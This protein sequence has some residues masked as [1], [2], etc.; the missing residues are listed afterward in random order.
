MEIR[1]VAKKVPCILCLWV[2]LLATADPAQAYVDPGT[3]SMVLQLLG[4]AI[5]GGLFFLRSARHRLIAWVSSLRVRGQAA[6]PG[7]PKNE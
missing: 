1:V 6:G 5:A 3:G 7:E 4:A 2:A